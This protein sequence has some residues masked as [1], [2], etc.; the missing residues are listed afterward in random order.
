MSIRHCQRCLAKHLPRPRD[1]GGLLGCAW[2]ETD[3]ESADRATL[4]RY[5]LDRHADGVPVSGNAADHGLQGPM[6]PRFAPQPRE[7]R[8]RS[9]L[10][11]CDDRG[12]GW[13]CQGLGNEQVH[14]YT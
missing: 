4:I 11:R 8:Q 10:Y 12:A 7:H 5:M 1:F 3:A 13:P 14:P 6:S 9:R 2:R